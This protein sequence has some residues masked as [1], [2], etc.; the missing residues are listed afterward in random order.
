MKKSPL[1]MVKEQF[2]SK[3]K[4]VD[5]LLSMVERG[6]DSKEEFKERLTSMSNKKLLRLHECHVVLK[7]KFGGKDK[8][9]D[10]LLGLMKRSKDNDYG[11]KLKTL[12]PVRLLALYQEWEKKS[13]KAK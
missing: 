7:E 12:T 3:D 1:M 9:V 10:S 4:L 13:K 2:G 8:L 11:T 5:K 6:E